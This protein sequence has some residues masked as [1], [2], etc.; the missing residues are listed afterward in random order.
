MT[1][2]EFC[3]A[4]DEATMELMPRGEA[5]VLRSVINQIH[6][7]AKN[8]LLTDLLQA[9]RVLDDPLPLIQ[10][11]A[12]RDQ[13][14]TKYV[15]ILRRHR[16]IILRGSTGL[17]KTSL[18]RLVTDNLGWRVGLGLFSRPCTYPNC[19]SSKENCI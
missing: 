16:T 14:V 15:A 4:F 9:P 11:V 3:L 7:I 8:T 5:A 18:A 10:G 1:Y 6:P 17:G 19:R 2:A 12:K 13:L